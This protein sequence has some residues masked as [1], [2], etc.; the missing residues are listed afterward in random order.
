MGDIE[1]LKL[2]IDYFKMFFAD[3]MLKHNAHHA[4]LNSAQQN[5]A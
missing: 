1:K 3:E 5:I 4:N 2:V